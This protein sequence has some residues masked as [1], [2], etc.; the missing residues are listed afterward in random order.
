M[1]APEKTATKLAIAALLSLAV[2]VTAM[3]IFLSRDLPGVSTE[4]LSYPATDFK[5][6]FGT[7]HPNEER[8]VVD[9]FANGYALLSSGPLN[10][11]GVAKSLNSGFSLQ[12]ITA[13]LWK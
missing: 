13:R 6:V 1:M 5:L 9:G 12:V 2:V 3:V 7:G 4:P 10:P 8:M 11:T